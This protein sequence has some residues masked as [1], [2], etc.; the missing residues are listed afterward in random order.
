MRP[1][2]DSVGGTVRMP[3]DKSMSHRALMF[4][5]LAT[6]RSRVRGILQSDD[7]QSTANALR[8]LGWSL[9]VVGDAMT[10][11]GG[12]LR[13]PAPAPLSQVDCGNSGTT[14]RLVAGIAA[15]QHFAS[16]FVGD[17]SLSRRPMR[18]LAAPLEA[19]GARVHF[20][21]GHDGLPMTVHGGALHSVAWE[22]PV[23]S[24]QLKSAVL[25][26]GLCGG[27]SVRVHEPAPTRD[28]TE[29]MLS[30]AGVTVSSVDGWITLQ[31]VQ[32]LA[33]LDLDVPG[34]PS[35][36]AFFVARALLAE[37]G[38]IRIENVL[39]SP[40]RD[41]FLHVVRRMGA[42]VDESI[43]AQDGGGSRNALTVHAGALLSGTSVGRDE[44]SAMIDEI[45]M[46]AVLAARAEGET[47][48]RGA[49]ELRVKES[50]RIT[51]VVSNLR[52]IGVDADEVPDGLIVRGT[53]APLRGHVITHAD[54]RIA[55][56][57]AVLGASRDCAITLDDPEC[58]SVSYPG[59]WRDLAHVAR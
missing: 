25:L 55:M 10:I 38:S 17:A 30:A 49:E 18:R 11:D 19:M 57:F 59:F 56:A 22:L 7:V 23:A 40:F 36:A 42:L 15:A 46:L 54:H 8:S 20:V 26:A 21:D 51:A 37:R 43:D 6:G 35:S 24:A 1:P 29:Q 5:A 53:R 28:H 2:I 50:D 33:P 3:G 41:G 45:P 52:A 27:V 12:G 32:S 44:V 9:P 4:S 48:V 34:D 13:S 31:P 47:V 16:T 58:V 14:T 39:R